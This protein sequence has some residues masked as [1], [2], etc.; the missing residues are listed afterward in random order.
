MAMMTDHWQVIEDA[1]DKAEQLA[2]IASDWNLDEVEIN[3]EMIDIYDLRAEFET[4]LAFVRE[5]RE[6]I[7]ELEAQ[8]AEARI[9]A[10]M[11]HDRAMGG[12]ME[13][14]DE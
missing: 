5:Q 14:D 9:D 10:Q 6:R 4:A 11:W 3:G 1:I 13:D 12:W 8:L 7:A 2:N